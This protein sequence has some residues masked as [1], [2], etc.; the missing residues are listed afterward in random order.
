MLK[1]IF[2][3]LLLLS[4]VS[5]S[6]AARVGPP[7]T[8]GVPYTDLQGKASP[9]Q[10]PAD[11]LPDGLFYLKKLEKGWSVFGALPTDKLPGNC[12]ATLV[13]GDNDGSIASIIKDM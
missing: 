8:K 9:T 2:V 3:A 10:K 11:K 1:S 4:F 5:S 12:T 6:E 13:Y 7:V